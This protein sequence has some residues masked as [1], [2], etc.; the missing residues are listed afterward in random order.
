MSADT[1]TTP[2]F[3]CPAC[4]KKHRADLSAL[5]DGSLAL[6][7]V[8]CARCEVVMSI[9]LGS[10]GLPKCEAQLRPE[11]RV[12]PLYQDQ[13]AA[14]SPVSASP[15][16]AARSSSPADGVP[17]PQAPPP[18]SP[19]P[20]ATPPKTSAG[21][22]VADRTRNSLPLQLA[23]AALVGA[24]VSFLVAS[25]A[26]PGPAEQVSAPDTRVE[27]VLRQMSSLETRLHA[28]EEALALERSTRVDAEKELRVAIASNATGLN[29]QGETVTR[30]EQLQISSSTAVKKIQASYQQLHGRIERNYTEASALKRR[31]DKL[32]GK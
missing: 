26:Q 17:M 18:Q 2:P 15:D 20:Q 5:G 21:G 30:M 11:P 1:P 23:A 9:F 12:D 19:P 28:S 27:Q 6:A 10:D 29:A 13:S 7:R 22:A 31:I 3:Y 16:V 25:A 4:G 8:T 32:S 14:T 24:L